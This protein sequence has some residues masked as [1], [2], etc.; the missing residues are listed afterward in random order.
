[1][2]IENRSIYNELVILE[3][4]KGLLIQSCIQ[5][6]K[7]NMDLSNSEI[8]IIILEN[9]YYGCTIIHGLQMYKPF[10]SIANYA[11][12][13]TTLF[14]NE[15]YNWILFVPKYEFVQQQNIQPEIEDCLNCKLTRY[16]TTKGNDLLLKRQ[17]Y[18]FGLGSE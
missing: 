4:N 2:I 1:M 10:I 18:A 9:D 13:H 15:T 6:E 17:C 11:L 8:P 3:T 12:T 7:Y 5:S 14:M 16:A